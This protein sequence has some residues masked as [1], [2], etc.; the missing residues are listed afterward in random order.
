[1]HIETTI[2]VN[3]HILEMLNNGAAITDKSRT[4]IIKSLFQMFMKD[5]QR[6][7]KTNSRVK[8]Q[9]M[10]LKENWHKIHIVLNEYEY[11][12]YLDI[13]KLYKMSV[14][15]IL[16]YAV[17]RYLD[18]LLK[19][20]ISTDKYCYKNYIL[21]KKTVDGIISWQIYWGIPPNLTI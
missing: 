2:N 21:I 7:I 18:E 16:A 3:K 8:Y 9:E 10:D 14:S 15:F 20:N 1:M 12:Y 6:M 11:E 4:S 19:Q 5:S 17:L 13:R